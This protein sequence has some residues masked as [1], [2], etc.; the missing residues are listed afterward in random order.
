VLQTGVASLDV[1]RFYGILA[2][3]GT[4]AEV[5]RKLCLAFKGALD[6]AEIQKKM[7]DRGSEPAWMGRDQFVSFLTREMPR[8][9]QAVKA[10][11][12]KLD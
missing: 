3:K 9:A 11:G 4:P 6:A 8:W 7:G 1:A 12:A 2:P 5:V 10:A